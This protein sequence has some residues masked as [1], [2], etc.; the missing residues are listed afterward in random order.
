MYEPLISVIIPVYNVAKWLPR[1]IDSIMTQTYRNLEIILVNDGSTDES[2]TICYD[3]D[4]RDDRIHVYHKPNG[5]LSD[6]RNY[7]LNICKG[8]YVA[9]VDSDD[10]IEHE[11]YQQMVTAA[12]EKG[13]KLVCCGM[14]RVYERKR[15]YKRYLRFCNGKLNI[16][17]Q[18]QA[19]EEFLCLRGISSAAWDKLYH[20][21]LFEKRRYPKGR[22][23]E[24]T[25]ITFDILS[26]IDEVVQIG[27][28]YYNYFQRKTSINGVSFNK[29]KMV[30]FQEVTNIRD[31][32]ISEFSSLKNQAEA[33]YF[34]YV[35]VLLFML[36]TSSNKFPD[37]KYVLLEAFYKNSKKAFHN[38]Y[39]S[40]L[41]KLKIIIVKFRLCKIF[42]LLKFRV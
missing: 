18:K 32:I 11:M 30:L 36:L 26:N 27:K 33:F 41:D 3:Y 12:I 28:P 13:A 34:S 25:P 35:E 1:C 15:K 2:G 9:F 21:S 31:S 40:N 20:C 37:E 23:Y 29:D 6:A 19:L 22:L 4:K 5:G 16:W 10:W 7:G 42:N 8:E 38:K 39:I 17:D 24:D 14:Y